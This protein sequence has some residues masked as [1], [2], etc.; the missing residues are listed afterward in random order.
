LT[1]PFPT[2]A[3]RPLTAIEV[4]NPSHYGGAAARGAPLTNGNASSF[5]PPAPATPA[6]CAPR[7]ASEPPPSIQAPFQDINWSE[8]G[9]QY[10]P[11]L[12]IANPHIGS[13]PPPNRHSTDFQAVIVVDGSYQGN[14]NAERFQQAGCAFICHLLDRNETWIAAKHLP[15]STGNNSAP[16]S[17]AEATL[18]AS[19]FLVDKGISRALFVHDNYDMHSFIC[20]KSRSAKRCS[21]YAK[22]KDRVVQGCQ[23]AGTYGRRVLLTCTKP[24]TRRP[25]RKCSCGPTCCSM[26]ETPADDRLTP[27]QT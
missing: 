4:S 20:N 16:V 15:K 9:L 27:N 22:L 17:E 23:S 11:S 1:L 3:Y 5:D 19:E 12:P 2:A 7:A 24:S 25:C 14:K 26:D 21:R 18:L 6:S 10:V 8:I 13:G